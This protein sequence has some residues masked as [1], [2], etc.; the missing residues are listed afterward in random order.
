MDRKDELLETLNNLIKV[1][2]PIKFEMFNTI[3]TAKDQKSLERLK[4]RNPKIVTRYIDYENPSSSLCVSS[5]AI[6]STITNILTDK[7]LAFQID[8]N[9]YVT[10]VQWYEEDNE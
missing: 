5:M 8:E 10:G 7:R 6:I 2:D 3:C 1:L 4:R 9:G